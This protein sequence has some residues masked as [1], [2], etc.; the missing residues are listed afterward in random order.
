MVRCCSGQSDVSWGCLGTLHS[1]IVPLLPVWTQPRIWRGKV[2]CDNNVTNWWSG[3]NTHRMLA[4]VELL[5]Q[6]SISYVWNSCSEGKI[7][8]RGLGDFRWVSVSRSRIHF[9]IKKIFILSKVSAHFLS[10]HMHSYCLSI[11]FSVVI[12]FSLAFDQKRIL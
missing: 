5:H 12:P 3:E 6:P 7:T 1:P 11:F 2:F 8:P 10:I 9:L 4:F